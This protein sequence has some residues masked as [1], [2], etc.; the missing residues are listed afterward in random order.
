M[1]FETLAVHAGYR[2]DPT[3]GAVA[4]PI[5]LSTTFERAPDGSYPGGF[6][7]VRDANPNRSA[8]EE[9]LRQLEGGAAA[10]AFASGMAATHA[11]FQA[12]GPGDH[13]LI[14]QDAYYGLI[15]LVEDLLARWGLVSTAVDMTDLAAVERALRPQTR[16]VW[17]ETP[18]NPLI[19]ITDIAAVA[20][21]A[22]GAGAR[23]VCDN[24]WATPMLTRPLEL[25]ADLVMHATTKYL[26][27][28]SDVMGGA[29]IAR[30]DDEFFQR[31]RFVQAKGGAIAAPF[32]AWLVLRGVRSLPWR[33]RAH[34]D[35]A[36]TLARFLAG[37][38][39]VA[40]VH[41][42][43]LET[44]PGHAVAAKQM[45]RFGGMLSFEV[46]GGRAEAM[47]LT[48]RLRLFTR[49]TSLGGP[50]TLIEHRAS[51]EGPSTRAPEGLLR[52]SVGLE[53]PDDLVDDMSRALG[54]IS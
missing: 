34:C 48:T 32:D 30:G 10:A 46:R 37:H 35:A 3:T 49:A 21:L 5:Y 22:H 28:H 7:Y 47:G 36:M 51:V 53:H 6:V 8:L 44:H 20:R 17:I 18:S 40:R 16:L 42:P 24:T 4:P 38:P 1:R 39:A 23:V 9:C 14:P 25:G 2:I 19:R 11:V 13:V 29:L 54:A 15:K 12:L 52:V 41:Y 43:G 45:A 27:G 33:M 31:V 50:E 26:G